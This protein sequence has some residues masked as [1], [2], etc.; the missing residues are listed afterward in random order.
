MS[1][2]INPKVKVSN[3]LHTNLIEAKDNTDFTIG[4]FSPQIVVTSLLLEPN[5]PKKMFYLANRQCKVVSVG[6]IHI[7]KAPVDNSF[8]LKKNDTDIM[9][10][11]GSLTKDINTPTLETIT[12]SDNLLNP[13]DYIT[14]EAEDSTALTNYSGVVTMAINIL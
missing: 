9:Y 10:V 1:S 14:L 8:I 4:G 6:E 13:G 7:V 3:T 11:V 2:I 5:T 12:D